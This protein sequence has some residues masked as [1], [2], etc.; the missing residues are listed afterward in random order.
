M[1]SM[2]KQHL[3]R[4]LHG[5]PSQWLKDT[6]S[7]GFTFPIQ[8]H[9]ILNKDFRRPDCSAHD[10]NSYNTT[11]HKTNLINKGVEAGELLPMANPPPNCAILHNWAVPKPHS[12]D[13]RLV[14]DFT[15]ANRAAPKPPSFRLIQPKDV[16]RALHRG[17]WMTSLDIKSAFQHLKPARH[18]PTT[19]IYSSTT[20]RYYQHTSMGFGLSWAPYLWIRTLRE[21]LK[22]AKAALPFAAVLDF[23][24]DLLIITDTKEQ[25]IRATAEIVAQLES[26]GITINRKKSQFTPTQ[27]INYLGFLFNTANM[28]ITLSKEKRL[29]CQLKI[30]NLLS[31]KMV[32]IKDI[33]SLLG[34]LE[35]SVPSTHQIRSHFQP[36]QHFLQLSLR[37]FSH[38]KTSNAFKQ[39]VPKTDALQN[40]L[41]DL[42]LLMLQPNTTTADLEAPPPRGD[43]LDRCFRH[44]MGSGPAAPSYTPTKRRS[45]SLSRTRAVQTIRRIIHRSVQTSA[46][47]KSAADEST[48]D[49]KQSNPRLLAKEASQRL[50]QQQWLYAT[51][52]PPT[53]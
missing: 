47:I 16:G 32:C 46:P 20:G 5:R 8:S 49:A 17:Q 13:W 11:N 39:K 23:F 1:H 10:T 4:W 51:S 2:V 26:A 36:L 24:D 44:R 35:A 53:T 9:L 30:K 50:K 31:R 28:T 34:S 12:P 45:R 7:R 14:T 42:R 22:P 48:Q 15:P 19:C 21:I 18:M 29:K 43:N 38:L 33:A 6:A 3:G 25:A 41:K 40:C 52:A 27:Q 37:G